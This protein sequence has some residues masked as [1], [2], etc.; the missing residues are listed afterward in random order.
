[1]KLRRFYGGN[2]ASS[3]VQSLD[4]GAG[5]FVCVAGCEGGGD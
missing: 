1:M 4:R 2:A 5:W 3:S